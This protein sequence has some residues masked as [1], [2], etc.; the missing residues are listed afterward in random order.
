MLQLKLT[1]AKGSWRILESAP[2]LFKEKRQSFV[3]QDHSPPHVSPKLQ[4]NLKIKHCFQNL[5]HNPDVRLFIVSIFF[6][7]LK[8][9]MHM[10]TVKMPTGLIRE[11][12]QATGFYKTVSTLYL[13]FK[14]WGKKKNLSSGKQQVP[15]VVWTSK[16]KI[17]CKGP[18]GW[19]GQRCPEITENKKGDI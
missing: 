8:V 4:K 15:K 2:F 3:I 9:K 1:H 10:F 5:A 7:P 11:H 19:S 13:P 18:G 12:S 17:E 14:M 6:M 16:V